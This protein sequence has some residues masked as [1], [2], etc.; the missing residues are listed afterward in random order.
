ME[1]KDDS[2]N[3]RQKRTG[4]AGYSPLGRKR[5]QVSRRALEKRL[6]KSVAVSNADELAAYKAS[7]SDVEILRAFR[8]ELA[9]ARFGTGIVVRLSGK[10]KKFSVTEIDIDFCD[11]QA[12]H[13]M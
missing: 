2:G 7:L 4:C 1:E 12:V 3:H 10:K 8:R 9:I 5:V 6:K 13:Q 11:A